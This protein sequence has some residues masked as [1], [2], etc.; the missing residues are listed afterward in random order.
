MKDSLIPI[1]GE[2]NMIREFLKLSN[3][4]TGGQNH[5]N[6]QDHERHSRNADYSMSTRQ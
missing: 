4:R 5:E 1:V 3:I 2:E 6:K